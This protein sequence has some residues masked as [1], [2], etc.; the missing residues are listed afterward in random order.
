MT[1][2]KLKAMPRTGKS[3]ELRRHGM[4]PAVVYGKG[5]ASEPVEVD[6]RELENILGRQG[7]NV[8][9]NLVLSGKKSQNKH[10]VMVKDL[11]RDPVG[12]K[13]LHADLCKISLRDKIHTNAPV[14]LTGEAV[15][16]KEGGIIQHG[17]RELEI[18]CLPANIPEHLEVDISGLAIG[19]HLTVADLSEHPD[20]KVLADPGAIL[21][22]VV[23]P[24]MAEQP[25]TTEAA[26][27]VAAP[28]A[29]PEATKEDAKTAEEKAGE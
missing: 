2:A 16:I 22:T 13:I 17:L 3:R 18:E 8:L 14:H 10:V 27:P 24:R 6:S 7:K 28:A 23:A 15:G 11:Q 4:V 12:R 25:E 20:Y 29:K 5:M 21:V 19:D 1:E 26:G 9:I